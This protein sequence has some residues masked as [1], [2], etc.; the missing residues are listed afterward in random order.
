MPLQEEIENDQ[1]IFYLFQSTF[2]KDFDE[3]KLHVSVFIVT[4]ANLYN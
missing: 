1:N 3:E 4:V 2:E